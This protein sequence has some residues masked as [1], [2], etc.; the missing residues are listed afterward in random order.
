M[1]QIAIIIF[2]DFTD[3]DFFLLRDILGR[4]Q[5]D[6]AVKILGTKP[7]HISTLGMEVKTDGH[8][9]EASEADVVLFSSGYK[10]IPAALN[11]HE[12]MASLK[13]NPQNQLIGSICAGAF[14]LA[15]LGLLDGITATT[16]PDA[17]SALEAEGI[18]VLDKALVVHGNLATAGGCLSQLYLTGWLAERLYGVDKRREIHRQLIPAGQS[19][20]FETLISRT[21]S[22][23]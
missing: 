19:E 14:I 18:Y 9:A 21:L 16:H 11:N 10:G 12:F 7:S 20:M 6:W 5:K 3:I 2:D 13:L 4:S 23:A 17:K 1:Y 8:V 15:K 22:E